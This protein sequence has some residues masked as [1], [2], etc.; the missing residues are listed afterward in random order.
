[1]LFSPFYR[2]ESVALWGRNGKRESWDGGLE[3]ETAGLCTAPHFKAVGIMNDYQ[4][5]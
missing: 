4:V 1:M 5:Q 3:R 2:K